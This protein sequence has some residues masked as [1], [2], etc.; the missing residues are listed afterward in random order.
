MTC[1]PACK[2]NK[3]II[4]QA[5]YPCFDDQINN[6]KTYK[7][8]VNHRGCKLSCYVPIPFLMLFMKKKCRKIG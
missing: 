6:Q 1:G 5:K 2:H 7:M 3:S 8:R 4:F